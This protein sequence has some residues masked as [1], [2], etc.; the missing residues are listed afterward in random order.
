MLE[1]RDDLMRSIT[2]MDLSSKKVI[3]RCDYNVPMKEGIIEDDTRIKESLETINY[4]LKNNCKIIILSHLGKIKEK[5]DKEKNSL[6]LVS[7]RLGELLHRNV[8]FSRD[9]RG[10]ELTKMA[11]NLKE[12]EILLV[13]NTRYEDLDGNKESSCDMELASYWA[14]LGEIFVNDAYGTLHRKHASNVGIAKL[15]PSCIGFLVQKEINKID[16]LLDEDTHPF[17]VIMGGAKVSDKIKVIDNLL[18]KCDKLLIGGG[19]AYTF[20]KALDYNVGSSLVDIDSLDYAK[21]ILKNYKN[22]IVLPVDAV[23]CKEISEDARCINKN[24]DCILDDEMGLDIGEE[25][26][27][28]FEYQ[29]CNAKRVIMNGPMGVFEIEKFSYG[30][31]SIY[32]YLYKNNIKTLIGG[33]D[34][35]ASVNKLGYANKF[36]HVSTGGGATLE[37]LEGKVLPGLSVIEDGK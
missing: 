18:D 27:K 19:M 32:D 2:D 6:Y 25:T 29:L 21:G 24:I 36:Y 11:S 10:T 12:G 22:K 30:T 8:L 31:E 28:L 23:V 16:S 15:L 13:E 1:S 33:G 17:V 14:S 4:L 20:L 9:T 5:S 35:V 3:L 7:V 26:I 34:S 37:Y